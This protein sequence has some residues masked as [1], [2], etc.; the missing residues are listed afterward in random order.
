MERCGS[1][2]VVTRTH[3]SSTITFRSPR[4]TTSGRPHNTN[5]D[6]TNH[7]KAQESR[8]AIHGTG[9]GPSRAKPGRP[10]GR[11]PRPTS[12]DRNPPLLNPHPPLRPRSQ[13]PQSFGGCPRLRC[14][15]AVREPPPPDDHQSDGEEKRVIE[16]YDALK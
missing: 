1:G 14:S 5:Y 8:F 11:H 9:R 4:Q 10:V 16:V 15:G 12:W 13:S 2:L 7:H 6:R 3:H